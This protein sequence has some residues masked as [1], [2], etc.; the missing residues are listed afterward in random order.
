[1]A[2]WTMYDP[3]LAKIFYIEEVDRGGNQVDTLTTTKLKSMVADLITDGLLT[4][5]VE[6]T[7]EPNSSTVAYP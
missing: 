3:T 2:K 5:A 7:V 4:S 6:I 1:M